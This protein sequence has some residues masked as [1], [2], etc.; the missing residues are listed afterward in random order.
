VS[1]YRADETEGRRRGP[2]EAASAWTCG[3]WPP[4]LAPAP[5]PAPDH[6]KAQAGRWNGGLG[7]S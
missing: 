1:H 4:D 7:L 2:E 5:A 6:D 3:P